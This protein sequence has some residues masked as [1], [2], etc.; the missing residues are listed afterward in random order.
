MSGA[1]PTTSNRSPSPSI[2]PG[3]HSP[4]ESPGTTTSDTRT[5]TVSSLPRS[6]TTTP[7]AKTPTSAEG[8]DVP[9]VTTA[10]DGT[11]SWLPQV[12]EANQI[13][14]TPSVPPPVETESKGSSSVDTR[15]A[16]QS[17]PAPVGPQASSEAIPFAPMS[18]STTVVLV[19]NQGSE[20]SSTSVGDATFTDSP[21]ISQTA[22][23][24]SR[25]RLVPTMTALPSKTHAGLS[26][27]SGVS[28]QTTSGN[29]PHTSHSPSNG[30]DHGLVAEEMGGST[31]SNSTTSRISTSTSTTDFSTSFT[32]TSSATSMS[33]SV[34]ALQ[35]TYVSNGVTLTGQDAVAALAA[36]QTQTATDASAAK[37][38]AGSANEDD[39]SGLS[40]ISIVGIVGGVLVALI[41]IY[42]TWSQWRK[43]QARKTLGDELPD[44][45]EDDN[46]DEKR[47]RDAY[48]NRMTRSSFGAEEPVTPLTYRRRRQHDTYIDEY[49]TTVYDPTQTYYNDRGQSKYYSDNEP[50][51]PFGDTNYED[52]RNEYGL[53]QYGDGMTAA[54][55]DGMVTGGTG[56]PAQNPFVPIPPVPRVPSTYAPNKQ[57]TIRSLPAHAPS[58]IGADER[59]TNCG[60]SI[61]DV[62]GESQSRPATQFSEPSTSKLLPWLN[63]GQEPP[64]PQVPT[65]SAHSWDQGLTPPGIRAP[66]PTRSPPR[67]VM[68]QIQQETAQVGYGGELEGVP[69]PEFR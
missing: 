13:E 21:S 50:I 63:K 18:K 62:Y 5:G 6:A 68:A 4:E 20:S 24:Q 7:P 47:R 59:E 3:N 19:T 2:S 51:A 11:V 25:S 15:T 10:K 16:M 9:L 22:T 61:Y 12:V 29:L 45:D 69:I 67:A 38:K 37:A 57:E 52:G 43:K 32:M 31:I 54:L 14:Q 23:S 39:K 27:G 35:T 49:G 8:L 17:I 1:Q 26:S 64:V 46:D 40:S 36:A 33:D 58:Q 48:D 60:G 53:T 65:Q 44:G 55:A 30:L 56:A 41:L 34:S 28:N 66:E 42:L